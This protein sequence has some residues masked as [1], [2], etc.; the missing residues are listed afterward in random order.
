[1]ARPQLRI[2][3]VGVGDLICSAFCSGGGEHIPAL[4]VVIKEIF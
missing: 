4:L 2:F 1:M 3:G